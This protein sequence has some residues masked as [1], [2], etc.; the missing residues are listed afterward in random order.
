MSTQDLNA[1]LSAFQAV[2]N[3]TSP[4]VEHSV[5]QAALAGVQSTTGRT[6]ERHLD[7]AVQAVCGREGVRALARGGVLVA[8]GVPAPG[9]GTYSEVHPHPLYGNNFPE[10]DLDRT[11][12]A[13]LC[14]RGDL[15]G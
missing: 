7:R 4:L 14:F 12:R 5:V 15:L 10:G 2:Y 9:I 8:L 6:A 1:K 3:S 13:N 11:Y